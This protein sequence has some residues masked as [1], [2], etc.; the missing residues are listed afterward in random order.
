MK[1]RIPGRIKNIIKE[2]DNEFRNIFSDRLKKIILYGSYA[3]GDYSEGSDIDLILLI[4]NMK[5][6][7]SERN[8]YLPIISSLSLKNDIL[9]SAI[10]YNYKDFYNNKTPL[11]LNIKREGVE[12]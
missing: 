4:D 11:L 5:D 10:P 2:A 9:I 6:V 1:K 7:K 3:R 12:I 8:N